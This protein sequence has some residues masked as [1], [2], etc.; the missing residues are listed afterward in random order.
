MK[1]AITGGRGYLG[2][3]FID[4]VKTK[5]KVIKLP[6]VRLNEK[7]NFYSRK[8]NLSEVL[9]RNKVDT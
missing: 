8:G 1:I 5:I 9:N 3:N 7:K 4:F 2:R 6:K